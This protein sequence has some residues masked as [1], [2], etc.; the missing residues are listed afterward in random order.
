[1]TTTRGAAR[2]ESQLPKASRVL[3]LGEGPRLT[4][5]AIRDTLHAQGYGVVL[6]EGGPRL[7]ASLVAENLL[8]EL[9]L[10]LSPVLA[11]RIDNL[12]PPRT[13]PGL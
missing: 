13:D 12:E 7:T 2:F 10:T 3:V 6:T 5:R 1:M 9:F 4:G 11:G 8:G